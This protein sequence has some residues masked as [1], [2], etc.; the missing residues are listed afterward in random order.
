MTYSFF[1]TPFAAFAL[2][3]PNTGASATVRPVAS[4]T[5]RRSEVVRVSDLDM[6]TPA[7]KAV[8]RHRIRAAAW[9]VCQITGASRFPASRCLSESLA[10]AEY[11][12]AAK[13]PAVSR[14]DG[15]ATASVGPSNL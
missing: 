10:R 15:T 14:H 12:L 13:T 6:T 5:D 7:G 1:V 8:A 4:D 9:R 2:L 11:D 3:V